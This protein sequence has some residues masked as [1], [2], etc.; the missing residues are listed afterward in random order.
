MNKCILSKIKQK[1]KKNNITEKTFKEK[2]TR[3]HAEVQILD[4]FK[5]TIHIYTY[6]SLISNKNEHPNVETINFPIYLKL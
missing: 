6:T 4:F 2:I 5:Y 1:L 3:I